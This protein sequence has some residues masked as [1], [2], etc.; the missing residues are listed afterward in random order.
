MGASASSRVQLVIEGLDFLSNPLGK[1]KGSLIEFKDAFK[2]TAAEIREADL[3]LK[4]MERIG[5]LSKSLEADEKALDKVT[6][7]L[8]EFELAIDSSTEGTGKM[9]EALISLRREKE[10]LAAD[11]KKSKKLLSEE[12]Q[13]LKDQGV[14][15]DHLGDEYKK[16]SG[17]KES[18]VVKDKAD[19][20]RF[21]AA[22]AKRRDFNARKGQLQDGMGN[23]AALSAA[24]V[25]SIFLLK[26][27]VN[28]AM[29]LQAGVNEVMS[30]GLFF[31]SETMTPEQKKAIRENLSNQALRMGAQLP[32]FNALDVVKLQNTA[33]TG[34]SK[35]ADITDSFIESILQY[36]LIDKMDPEDAFNTLES[37]RK[38]RAL[39]DPT[40]KDQSKLREISDVITFGTLKASMN[41]KDMASVFEEATGPGSMVNV[42]ERDIV[43][44][45]AVLADKIALKGPKAATALKN[46]LTSLI[47]QDNTT[48]KKLQ[49]MGIKFGDSKG[50][51]I[52]LTPALQ[53][54]HD[55]TQ[56]WGDMSRSALF[57]G[58]G[59]KEHIAAFS[60][61]VKMSGTK[62]GREE[63]NQ[64]QLEFD[65]EARDPNYKNKVRGSTGKVAAGL[66]QGLSPAMEELSGAFSGLNVVFGQ[67]LLE[68]V[69]KLVRLLTSSME[70]LTLVVKENPMFAKAAFWSVATAGVALL[71]SAVVA[72]T[73][74]MA[75]F[76]GIS[77]GT[78]AVVGVIGG[79]L[80]LAAAGW[81]DLI[82]D[83]K[84]RWQEF[85][86]WINEDVMGFVSK[87]S[88]VFD[89]GEKEKLHPRAPIKNMSD[90]DY[91]Q[92]FLERET[93]RN[94]EIFAGT[95]PRDV[96][97][98]A[99]VTVNVNG[100][101][102]S[103]ELA[104]EIQKK[105]QD[106]FEK[107][108][109]RDFSTRLFD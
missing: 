85:E 55:A 24:A 27:P 90:Q 3:K 30:K 78:V 71:G 31:E 61:L 93:A 44:F 60:T 58:I 77:A 54:I 81:E 9:S 50:N 16:Y 7:Q 89:F 41:T 102:N 56:N 13:T 20:E 88:D 108:Q 48:A 36:A 29:A 104:S 86:T 65:R 18:L 33:I 11:I 72:A 39:Y 73:S 74:A 17:K 67:T 42:S 101:A 98:S 46:M 52:G 45:A 43:S 83:I 1:A 75:A 37:I 106:A 38:T 80:S 47:S 82:N 35:F 96:S 84:R 14:A 49:E 62:E 40:Y 4:R 63:L 76:A 97:Y 92:K 6:K 79:T 95:A 107:M 8:K 32:G 12:T 34:G 109:Q 23:A 57:T 94:R 53:K 26:K 15:V 103:E 64:V 68:D 10:R 22:D 28:E 51:F 21:A 105:Q 99:P 91:Q 87:V 59:D 69:E 66:T 19:R 2:K 70:S 25:G 100:N 5:R